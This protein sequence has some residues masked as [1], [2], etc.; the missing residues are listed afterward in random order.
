[1]GKLIKAEHRPFS[2]PGRTRKMTKNEKREEAENGQ[3][4]KLIEKFFK[5]NYRF[6]E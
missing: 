1:M 6:N 3:N 5:V 2:I 4:R